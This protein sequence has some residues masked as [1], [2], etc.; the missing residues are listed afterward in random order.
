MET[1]KPQPF[2]ALTAAVLL[3][4]SLGSIHA[5]SIFIVPLESSYGASR[6]SVSL[7]YSIALV[8]LT[9]AVLASHRIFRSFKPAKLLILIGLVAAGGL[10]LPLLIDSLLAVHAGYGLVFGF[11]NGMGYAFA[12]QLAARANPD[13]GATNIGAVTAVYALGALLFA[14]VSHGAVTGGGFRNAFALLAVT[15]LLVGSVGAFAAHRSNVSLAAEGRAEGPSGTPQRTGLVPLLWLGYGTS[16]LAG[17]MAIGHAAGI[18]QAVG[19]SPAALTAAVVLIALGN[20]I[21]GFA[22]GFLADRFPVRRLL[23]LFSLLSGGALL[24][25][26]VTADPTTTLVGLA[27]IGLAYG[28]IIALYPAVTVTYFGVDRMAQV[29]GRIF[30]AWGAAGLLGPWIAGFLYDKTASYGAACLLAAAAAAAATIVSLTL[31][32]PVAVSTG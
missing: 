13:R 17:L 27:I 3:T 31:P 11:A 15:M 14:Q 23:A 6:E 12:L 8:S 26:A 10:L 18:L 29:Y 16:C 22:A 24:V 1:G 20:A 28:A 25:T 7:V 21:G 9:I 19:G 5:F 4:G 2:F 32:K 30:T